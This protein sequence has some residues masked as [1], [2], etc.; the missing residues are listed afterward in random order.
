[1]FLNQDD[2]ALNCLPVQVKLTE[3][4]NLMMR[5][6]YLIAFI[7]RKQH[8]LA[9]NECN[10]IGRMIKANEGTYYTTYNWINRL[11]A[12]YLNVQM[13]PRT[14]RYAEIEKLKNEITTNNDSAF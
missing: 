6:V 8:D 13:L 3:Q 9:V 14:Q 4:Q 5:M 11:F 10:N 12:R 2:E 1:L 7:M